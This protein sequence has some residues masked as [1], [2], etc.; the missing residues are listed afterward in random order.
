MI[1]P[2]FTTAPPGAGMVELQCPQLSNIESILFEL[3]FEIISAERDDIGLHTT[4]SFY[5]TFFISRTEEGQTFRGN[6]GDDFQLI[7]VTE[8]RDKH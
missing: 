1:V 4:E 2:I 3:K 5:F 8:F 7:D 6:N